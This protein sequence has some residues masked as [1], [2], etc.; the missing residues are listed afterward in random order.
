LVRCT[1]RTT[2]ARLARKSARGR[3]SWVGRIRAKAGSEKNVRKNVRKN[4]QPCPRVIQPQLLVGC[5]L[6]YCRSPANRAADRQVHRL[7]SRPVHLPLAREP[8]AIPKR[9]PHPQG[10]RRPATTTTTLHGQVQGSRLPR[11]RI[12]HT[13]PL[14]AGTGANY[15]DWLA[16]LQER[17]QRTDKEVRGSKGSGLILRSARPPEST[18]LKGPVLRSLVWA[19]GPPIGGTANGLP[20]SR[21]AFSAVGSSGWLGGPC[22]RH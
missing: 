8:V 20:L 11:T 17:P 7:V 10:Q 12:F 3:M 2:A 19:S 5:G 15:A 4:V 21:R 14:T 1:W 9:R 22:T 18:H 13:P 16:T 6:T